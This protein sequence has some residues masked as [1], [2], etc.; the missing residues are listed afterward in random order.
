M[1]RCLALCGASRCDP[2]DYA[3]DYGL[4]LMNMTCYSAADPDGQLFGHEGLTYGF[5][6][7]SGY[8]RC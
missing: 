1:L 7:R 4:G 5:H 3:F 6:S 8:V 2:F